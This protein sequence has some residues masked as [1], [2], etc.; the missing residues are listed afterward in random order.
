MAPTTGT[1]E[2]TFEFICN[3]CG[4]PLKCTPEQHPRSEGTK[5]G[6]RLHVRPCE[7]EAH[8]A[9]Q[10]LRSKLSNEA[11]RAIGDLVAGALEKAVNER[12]DES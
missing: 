9:A 10:T 5:Q 8:Y 11:Y 4:S 2:M 6:L 1:L 7:C 3:R 12:K